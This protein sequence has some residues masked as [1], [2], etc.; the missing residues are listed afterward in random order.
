VKKIEFYEKISNEAKR[1]VIS[2]F[3]PNVKPA[4]ADFVSTVLREC[5]SVVPHIYYVP[6]F[7]NYGK[8]VTSPQAGDLVIFCGTY[9]AVAPAGIGKEDDKTHVGIMISSSDFVHYSSSADKPILSKLSGYWL[10]HKESFLRMP[11]PVVAVSQFESAMQKIKDLGIVSGKH[12]EKEFVTW[13]E[14]S[15]V[16]L[17]S[18]KTS[19]VKKIVKKEL[20]KMKGSEN[21]MLSGILR[22]IYLVFVLIIGVEEPGNGAEKKAAVIAETKALLTTMGIKVPAFLESVL[23]AFLSLLIDNLVKYLNKNN[24]L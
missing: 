8:K 23:D 17:R 22:L 3:K 20:P 15:N 14:L 12:Y 11:A 5:G 19:E 16:I 1:R 6:N 13:G 18:L 24:I 10:D 7:F 9:D 2:G 21:N 4:C